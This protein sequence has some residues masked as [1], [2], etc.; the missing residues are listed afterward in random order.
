MMPQLALGAL[1][2]LALFT[3]L[4]GVYLYSADQARRRRAWRLL[5]LLLLRR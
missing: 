3:V 2:L 1:A 4:A 5:R